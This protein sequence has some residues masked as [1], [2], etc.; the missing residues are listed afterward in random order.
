[1]KC[2]PLIILFLRGLIQRM[3]KGSSSRST[4][5]LRWVLDFSCR[6]KRV[7]WELDPLTRM[8]AVSV[9]ASSH[10]NALCRSFGTGQPNCT[11]PQ[12][13]IRA[14]PTIQQP[15]PLTCCDLGIA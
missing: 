1:M 4:L 11:F 12:P 14:S 8:E 13:L 2:E 15:L 5:G 9:D 10:R 6:G 3:K 7:I